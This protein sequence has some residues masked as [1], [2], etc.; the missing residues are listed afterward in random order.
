VTAV[1]TLAA[2][3]ITS[4]DAA[5][6][7]S[8]Q[9]RPDGPIVLV[10]AVD[11]SG[12]GPQVQVTQAAATVLTFTK[13]DRTSAD[14]TAADRTAAGRTSFW[15]LD[16][17]SFA[18]FDLTSTLFCVTVVRHDAGRPEL[19]RT[20]VKGAATQSL[21]NS[22]NKPLGE[23]AHELQ[24]DISEILTGPTGLPNADDVIGTRWLILNEDDLTP[25]PAPGN[26]TA[27]LRFPA[28]HEGVFDL[29][30]KLSF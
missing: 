8:S 18:S 20:L 30:V 22:L 15:D 25:P 3:G 2:K 21:A 16:N 4:I 26:W 29:A 12:C 5:T 14:R 19:L 13:A 24:A 27:T 23:R 28:G 1:L 10:T 6:D 17:A 9:A 11:L 7:D